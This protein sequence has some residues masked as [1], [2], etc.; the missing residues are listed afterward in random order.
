MALST[1]R[2]EWDDLLER[3]PAFRATLAVYGEILEHWAHWAPK[4]LAS[5]AWS[6]P[7]CRQRWERGVPL[8]AEAAP[9]ISADE[10][11]ELLG[12]LMENVAEHREST[13]PSLQRLAQAWDRRAFGPEALLPTPG[14][15]GTGAVEDIS[16]LASDLVAF[17]AYGTLRPPLETYLA[18]TRAHLD[19]HVWKLGICPFC[20]APPGFSDVL[21]DGRRRL[22]CHLCGGGW[23]YS[24]LRCPF[25]GS[26]SSQD[27]VRLEPADQ[28][29]GYVVIACTRCRAYV[30]ELD[31]RVRWNAQSALIEDWGSPHFDLVAQRA[32]FQRPTPSLSAL[33]TGG[34]SASGMW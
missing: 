7:E 18:S 9:D 29:Q 5:L 2:A 28:D 14:R 17:L 26:E 23:T 19:D 22:A 12:A 6:V 27:L 32:G 1:L 15:I 20:G 21:E 33:A 8:L 4:R 30:K 34:Q 24:R 16:G 11:E 25:C 13:A 31:R 3:R 10:L